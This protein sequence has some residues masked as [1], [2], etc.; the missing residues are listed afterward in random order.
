MQ[1]PAAAARATVPPARLRRRSASAPTKPGAVAGSR[2]SSRRAAGRTRRR[3]NVTPLA[4][5]S[6]RG[7]ARRAP[8]AR[9]GRRAGGAA[10]AGG[11]HPTRLS[12]DRPGPGHPRGPGP[13]RRHASASTSSP[14]TTG[15]SSPAAARGLSALARPWLVPA[16]A[17]AASPS[18]SGSRCRPEPPRVWETARGPVALDRPVLVGILNVTPDSFSDGGRFAG[19]DAA[20]AQADALLEAGRR[21][22]STSAANPPGPAASEPVPEDEELAP[23]AC[24]WSRRSCAAIPE[25][26]L[27]VDTVK[28]EVARAALDAG[29]A[30]VNDVSGLRLDPGAGGAVAAQARAGLVLMHS[31]GPILEIASYAPRRLR[32]RR[33]REVAGRAARGACDAR[34]RP[35]SPPD[36]IVVDPGLGFSKT[37]E[38]NLVLF[39]Q[40]DGACR[41][42]AVRCWSV[43]RAS[44]FSAPSPASRSTQRDRATA[45]ACALAWER[46]ARLFR[47]HDV[48]AA[49]DALALAAGRR[50]SVVPLGQLPFP[51]PGWRDLLEILIVAYVRLRAAPVPRRHA[52]AAD[53]V[54]APGA[55]RSST[56]SRSCSS[57]SMITY[58]LGVVFTYGVF[59][60]LVVFQP[61]LRQALA[62]LGQTRGLPRCSARRP[63]TGVAEEIAEAVE[64]LSRSATGAIIA[65]EREVRLDEYL[66]SGTPHAGH[67]V[68]RP[69]R[70]DLQ[71]VLAAARRRRAGPR[72]RDRGRG[73]H[74]AAHA[75]SRQRP[76]ARHAASGGAR[77]VRGDRRA[78]ARGVGG[79]RRSSRSPARA[80]SSAHSRPSRCWPCST[81]RPAARPAPTR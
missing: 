57:S 53:R 7:G 37:P 26:P 77:A 35:A 70:D 54:R 28:A 15:P 46:G 36:A 71:P 27:S 34:P 52:R 3:V 65:V 6:P 48:A 31:R 29:A 42:S 74:P 58:L 49:R 72:R 21:R 45:A 47:V 40:L 12:S 61:E 69:A 79:D 38:Q 1:E 4:L 8:R 60:A 66:E 11:I 80:R 18:T 63:G 10:A 39:D 44:G 43:R 25:L 5:H 17:A 32:R 24:R 30:I 78:G 2:T 13:V 9:V 81:G 62:R 33:G 64:R 68:G 75:E 41:R 76:L 50:R 73:L 56:S 19:L 59:A 51:T 67:R 14:A 16:P 22:S 23:G 55:R 20:L